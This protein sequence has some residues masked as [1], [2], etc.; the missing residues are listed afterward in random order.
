ML[1]RDHEEICETHFH[2][3]TLSKD[4]RG[5]LVEIAEACH[6]DLVASGASRKLVK[7]KKMKTGDESSLLEEVTFTAQKLRG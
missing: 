7:E 6:T 4:F 3:T 1:T 5:A 2:A